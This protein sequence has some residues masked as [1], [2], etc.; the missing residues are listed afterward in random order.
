[1]TVDNEQRGRVSPLAGHTAR[2][3]ELPQ[4]VTVREV[5]FLTQ[6]DVRVDPSA[7]EAGALARVLGVDLPTRPCTAVTGADGVRVLWLGPD[8]WLVV[9]PPDRNAL[10]PALAEAFGSSGAVVDVSAHRTTIAISGPRTRDLLAHGCAIDLD[11]R[12]SPAGTC[13]QTRL[14]LANVILVVLD[15]ATTD[16]RLLVRSS[17]AR[18]L[19]DWLV[20]AGL[21]YRDVPSWR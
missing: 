21:E 11:P 6:L 10:E 7:P 5:P 8:E 20:D 17:F 1:M 16:V 18:Y 2:L 9:A 14:A 15:D 13:V 12:I 19:A 4:G 3:A